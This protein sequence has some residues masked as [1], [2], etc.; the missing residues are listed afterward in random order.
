MKNTIILS[1]VATMLLLFTG[2]DDKLD[3]QQ[4]Y[5]FSVGTM[6][7]QKKIRMGETVEIRCQLN[8]T[9]IYKPAQYY[10]GYFQSEGNG[11]LQY[12][13]YLLLLPNNFYEFENEFFRLYYTSHCQDQQVIDI[14]VLDNFNQEYKFS[15][16]FTNESIGRTPVSIAN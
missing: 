12:E 15:V 5:E 1:V 7:V 9:G 10:I 11:L 8:R 13:N 4:M 16:S 2:C 3:V 14:T 6:P